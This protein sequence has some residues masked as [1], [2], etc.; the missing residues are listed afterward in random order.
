M[1]KKESRKKSEAKHVFRRP[2]GIVQW[3]DMY[4]ATDKTRRAIMGLVLRDLSEQEKK[5]L[6]DGVKR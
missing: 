1:G 2:I 4:G 3:M 6:W 5:R